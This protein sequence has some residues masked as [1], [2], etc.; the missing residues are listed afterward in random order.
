MPDTYITVVGNSVAD[1][2]LRFMPNGQAVSNFSIAS[3]P[4][5]KVN[6]EWV[7]GETAFYRVSAFRALGEEC[8]DQIRKGTKLIVTGKFKVKSWEKDGVKR[9]DLTIDAEDVGISVRARREKAAAT[10]NAGWG[11]TADNDKAPF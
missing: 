9:T 7:D 11:T 6:D 8:A 1:A 3:T 2:E 10:S 4:R 5:Q